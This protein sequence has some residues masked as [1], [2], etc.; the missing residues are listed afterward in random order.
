MTTTEPGGC[1]WCGVPARE[2]YNR[3]TGEVGYHKWTAPTAGQLRGRMFARRRWQVYKRRNTWYAVAPR[4]RGRILRQTWR[5][6]T[7]TEAMHRATVTGITD[8][9]LKAG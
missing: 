1:R 9:Y 7:W 3:W 4:Q 2:H 8:T 6:D 5:Y